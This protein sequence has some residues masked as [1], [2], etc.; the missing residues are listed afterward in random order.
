MNADFGTHKVIE[1]AH[2]RTKT[3]KTLKTCGPKAERCAESAIYLAIGLERLILIRVGFLT[4]SGVCG[5]IQQNAQRAE[6]KEVCVD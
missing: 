6:K 3:I 4:Y 5:R 2:G 1:Y